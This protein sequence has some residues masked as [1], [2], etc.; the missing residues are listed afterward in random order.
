MEPTTKKWYQSKI[1]LLGALLGFTG[2]SDLFLH[3]I[4]GSVTVE[5]IQDVQ[6]AYPELYNGIA[7]AINGK[8]Y[9]GIITTV[10]GFL[11]AI[12]RG[13]FTNTTIFPRPP[14]GTGSPSGNPDAGST[15]SPGAG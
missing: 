3:W 9:F 2:L 10:A 5:Q 13:W 1:F 12:W 7:D 15:A 6:N 14:L 4:T 8:N 11:T